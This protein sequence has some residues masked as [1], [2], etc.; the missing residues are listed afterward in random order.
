MIFH[1]ENWLKV[2]FLVSLDFLAKKKYCEQGKASVI[3]KKK[4]HKSFCKREERMKIPQ[5]IHN[6]FPTSSKPNSYSIELLRRIFVCATAHFP[7]HTHFR[8][9]HSG[10]VLNSH[11]HRFSFSYRFFFCW[12]FCEYDR[13]I[14]RAFF[15]FSFFFLSFLI[16]QQNSTLFCSVSIQFRL[17][18]NRTNILLIITLK[19]NKKKYMKRENNI[20]V[21]CHKRK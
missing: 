15:S 12:L 8:L 9:F 6:T 3:K 20:F 17:A 2:F 14:L 18:W 21:S 5:R 4:W 13:I 7:I 10:L 19:N 11:S 1:V 16:Y